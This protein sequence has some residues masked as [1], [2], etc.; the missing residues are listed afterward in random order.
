MTLALSKAAEDGA[1]GGRLRVDRQ[2][3]G[4]GGGLR[5]A[6]PASRAWWS[7]RAAR[8]RSASSPRRRPSAP[9]VCAIDGSFDDALRLVRELCD[10]HPITLVNNLNPYRLEGQKTAAFEI[11]DELGV[12]PTGC[13]CP[14]G[15]AGNITAYWRGFN[16]AVAAGDAT[17]RPPRC[18][19]ARRPG[20]AAMLQGT[21]IAAARHDRD[22]DPDRPPGAPQRGGAGPPASRRAASWRRRT[23]RSSTGAAGIA[24]AGGRVLRA[25]QRHQR[26]RPRARPRAAGTVEEGA[27]V[28]CVLTG[29]GLK[30][31]DT[32]IARSPAVVRASRPR[33]RPSSASRS[34][35][36][37]DQL[38]ARR[39]GRPA[40][41]RPPRRAPRP[42][43]GGTR[44]ARGRAP[45]A[46]RGRG[47]TTSARGRRLPGAAQ[48]ARSARDRGAAAPV[49]WPRRSAPPRCASWRR[50]PTRRAP[51]SPS[52]RS[53]GTSATASGRIAAYFAARCATA[54]AN[55][56]SASPK[57][58]SE[59]IS[60]SRGRHACAREGAGWRP[61]RRARCRSRPGRSRRRWA[62][63]ERPVTKVWWN[64]SR[65]RV[66]ERH[67][68]AAAIATRP[69]DAVEGEAAEARRRQQPEHRHVRAACAARGR[70]SPSVTRRFACADSVKM[71]AAMTIAGSQ[72][73]RARTAAAYR[74]PVRSA[75]RSVTFRHRHARPPHGSLGPCDESSSSS[76]SGP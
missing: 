42:P 75:R 5:R 61:A 59:T 46:A 53:P 63:P 60:A 50:R 67:A 15:N 24:A 56:A 47:E 6:R 70:G 45:T 54:A 55:T 38:G 32:A 21:D 65:D 10:R 3:V 40:A 23:R 30:D 64:S 7:C 18:S 43:S 25:V 17:D 34:A 1:A 35:E 2:H 27:R 58:A 57:A 12:R 72:A 49:R 31:P 62:T 16:E 26:G 36:R 74:R 14:V 20:A 51:A 68:P 76:A 29:H 19:A 52:A 8:W 9:R 13:R 48:Q 44:A 69:G 37:G 22:G 71:I 4:L 28:V 11:V 33:S 39:D 73:A 41:A 66:G